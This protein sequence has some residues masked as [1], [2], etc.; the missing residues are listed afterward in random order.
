MKSSNT[1]RVVLLAAMLGLTTGFVGCK[2]QEESPVE[3]IQDGVGDALNTR[4]N[5]KLKDAGEDAK[6]AMN[7]AGEAVQE[8]A[9][10]TK[11]AVTQ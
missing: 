11:E 1:T 8:K 3:K 9:E 2:K 5:E 4:D 10:E 6:D 7:N